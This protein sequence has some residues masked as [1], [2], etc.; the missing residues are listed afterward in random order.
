V[1]PLA[2]DTDATAAPATIVTITPEAHAEL[3]ALR[4][5]EPDADRLGLRLEIISGP[6]EEFRYDLSFEVVTKAAFTDEVRTQLTTDLPPLKVIVPAKDVELL[7]GATLD[8]TGPQGLVIR[9]PN[10]PQAPVVEGLTTGDDLSAE[11][12]AVIAA[13]VN[14]ALAAHG[15]FVTYVG[16]DGEGTAYLTMG[17]GCHGCS[18]SRMTMLDGVQTMLVDTVAGVERVRDLTDHASGENPFYR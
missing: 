1:S 16:H 3:V 12:E 8:H 10:K 14:P 18:M 6:G 4:D 5:A 11:V 17:G 7:Q 9:N 13:E 2:P 15:G